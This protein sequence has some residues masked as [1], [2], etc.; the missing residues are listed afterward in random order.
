MRV[1]AG[2]GGAGHGGGGSQLLLSRLQS[3]GGSRCCFPGRPR[4]MGAVRPAEA[5]CRSLLA[6]AASRWA[7]LPVSVDRSL[8]PCCCLRCVPGSRCCA[9]CAPKPRSRLCP[10]HS[11]LLRYVIPS[12]FH[13]GA[14]PNPRAHLSPSPPRKGAKGPKFGSVRRAALG[15]AQGWSRLLLHALNTDS[16]RVKH[17]RAEGGLAVLSTQQRVGA[18]RQRSSFTA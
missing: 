8:C 10:S 14:V 11:L 9:L 3:A 2:G 6:P 18:V 16:R 13:H 1:V 12:T 7:P 5:S 4:R 17:L 15:W